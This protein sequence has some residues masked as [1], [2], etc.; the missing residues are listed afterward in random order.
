MPPASEE[1]ETRVLV[2]APIRRD[3]A[4]A[5]QVLHEAGIAT[6][7]FS[8][9]RQLRAEISEGAGAVLMTEEV[10]TP[11]AIEEL[12]E[13]FRNQLAWS[14]LPVLVFSAGEGRR[15]APQAGPAVAAERLDP[16]RNRRSQPAAEAQQ[17]Q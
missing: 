4:L 5:A 2:L 15:D 6:A 14:D 13:I 16:G 3:G 11:E 7:V 17:D 9:V 1:N 12:G 8:S 10:L